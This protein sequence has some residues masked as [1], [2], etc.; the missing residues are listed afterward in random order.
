[1]KLIPSRDTAPCS[2]VIL[3]PR[4]RSTYCLH[5]Q[6]DEYALIMEAVRTSETSVYFNETTRLFIPEGCHLHTRRLENLKSHTAVSMFCLPVVSSA[7]RLSPI[8]KGTGL[9][10]VQSPYQPTPHLLLPAAAV[11]QDCNL[12]SA[13]SVQLSF[14][15]LHLM[16]VLQAT[17]SRPDI[18]VKHCAY[19]H[20]VATLL[21]PRGVT[22]SHK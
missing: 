1:M 2:L 3:G 20:S 19:I 7:P 14:V 17:I 22:F 18:R 15:T 5:H 4:F 9:D 8:V 10:Y 16:H 11:R 6:D 13:R 12:R 21:N